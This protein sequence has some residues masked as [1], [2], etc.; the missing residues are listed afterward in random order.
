MEL[1]DR[2]VGNKNTRGER[3]EGRKMKS[4][5]DI[6]GR[7]GS[8]KDRSMYNTLMK[9]REKN[10]EREG[11]QQ[12]KQLSTERVEFKKKPNTL[13]GMEDKLSRGQ[14]G[15]RKDG[16]SAKKRKK[17][18]KHLTG[19]LSKQRA[20]LR[21]KKKGHLFLSLTAA[22]TCTDLKRPICKKEQNARGLHQALDYIQKEPQRRNN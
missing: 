21:R 11:E 4:R 10:T 19:F 18:K 3:K 20:E 12:P 7:N 6:K 2:E 1:P 13:K 9:E 17:K 5:Q 16:G 14:G 15:T 8:M 22:E